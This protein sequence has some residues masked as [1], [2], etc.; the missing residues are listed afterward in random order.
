MSNERANRAIKFNLMNGKSI[1]KRRFYNFSH[2]G[3]KIKTELKEVER[4]KRE[5]RSIL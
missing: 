1:S 2:T 3:L 5:K 4:K